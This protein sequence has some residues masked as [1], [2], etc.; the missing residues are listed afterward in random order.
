MKIVTVPGK[1]MLVSNNLIR[2]RNIEKKRRKTVG[3]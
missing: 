1:W 2:F 3:K